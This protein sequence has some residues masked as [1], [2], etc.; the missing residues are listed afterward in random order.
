MPP[1]E[2]PP[3]RLSP[4]FYAFVTGFLLLHAVMCGVRMVAPLMT[5]RQ[6]GG[7]AAAGLL[8][9]LCAIVPALLSL[10]VNRFADRHGLK[11]TLA[12]AVFLSVASCLLAAL[13]PVYASLVVTALL[14]GG[15]AGA[16]NVMVQ[17]QAGR[18]A[19]D[20]AQLRKVFSWISIATGLSNFLG[21]FVGGLMVDF[22]GWRAAFLLLALLGVLSWIGFSR[23]GS[24]PTRASGADAGGTAWDLWQ[25]PVFRRLMFMNWLMASCWDLHGFV[26]PVFGH[27]RGLTASV[28]GTL[29]GT[30]AVS[31]TAIRLFTPWIGV[32]WKEWQLILGANLLAGT[33][34]CV[35]PLMSSPLGMGVC[36]AIAGMALGFVQPMVMSLLHQITRAPRR[37]QAVAMRI[38]MVK[39]SG[40]G[41]PALFGLGGALMGASGVFWLVGAG[42]LTL[43]W[44][45]I[46]LRHAQVP[47]G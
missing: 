14:T 8:V 7:E 18:F 3:Q 15:A 22:A 41:M 39:T 29:L 28:I 31:A 37:G 11:C 26:V 45:G 24:E 42:V 9:A 4:A 17:A 12:W 25:Q 40:V 44:V 36:S 23:S 5:L 20:P 2:A 27:E 1:S 35:Y 21:P 32:H 30:F 33:I 6:G 38:M 19:R 10:L 34:F 46:G 13:W 43:C 47:P 16:A